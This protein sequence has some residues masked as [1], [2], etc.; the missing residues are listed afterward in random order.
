M[1]AAADAYDKNIPDSFTVLSN[2]KNLLEI[3][4]TEDPG[5]RN[6]SGCQSYP[7]APGLI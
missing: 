3:L 2:K 6:A 7:L 4:S 1:L 5:K